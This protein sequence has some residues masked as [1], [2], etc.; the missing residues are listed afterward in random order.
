MQEWNLKRPY[1]C[2]AC[3]L[4][5][6]TEELFDITREKLGQAF[7]YLGKTGAWHICETQHGCKRFL[8]ACYRFRIL[9]FYDPKI[10]Q[11]ISTDAFI[12]DVFLPT[13][14]NDVPVI[15]DRLHALFGS[16]IVDIYYYSIV[17]SPEFDLK[18]RS[19]PAPLS[20]YSKDITWV[21]D[22]ITTFYYRIF[23]SSANRAGFIRVS[24]WLTISYGLGDNIV[25]ELLNLVYEKIIY[26]MRKRGS[27]EVILGDDE[28][29]LLDGLARY[30]VPT[31]L[32]LFLQGLAIK[33]SIY[34]ASLGI[35][36]A[37][38]GSIAPLLQIWAVVILYI[39]LIPI[40]IFGWRMINRLAQLRW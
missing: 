9:V 8:L 33:V 5:T 2:F 35:L 15:L 1:I 21:D 30:T 17:I 32:N 38:L 18:Q 25:R 13:L 27:C 10:P 29:A 37:V 28:F 31:E 4:I 22:G 3:F 24:K 16:E 20:Q 19:S 23:D 7:H 12:R 34:I 26:S 11:A 36:L 14:N 40:S 6:P 39:L